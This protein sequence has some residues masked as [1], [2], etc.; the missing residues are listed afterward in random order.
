MNL[1]LALD[2]IPGDKPIIII[3][4]LEPKPKPGSA[5]PAS[6]HII[7]PWIRDIAVQYPNVALLELASCI[8]KPSE[9]HGMIHFDRAVYM[10]LYQAI[11]KLAKA[12]PQWR[13]DEAA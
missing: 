13:K 2:A 11:L 5:R 4:G 8:E 6:L 3:L 12:F 1:R 10:R 7:N 9:M